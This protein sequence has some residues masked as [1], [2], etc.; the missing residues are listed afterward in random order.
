MLEDCVNIASY[1]Q[2]QSC[3]P[4]PDLHSL[5]VFAHRPCLNIKPPGL[6]KACLGQPA[7]RS[8]RA[9]LVAAAH[10][11]LERPQG[12]VAGSG[13]GRRR[14]VK[15]ENETH[16]SRA[17]EEVLSKRG[18]RFH[19]FGREF[20]SVEG[21]D[22]SHLL[23]FP[24]IKL[25]PSINCRDE[26]FWETTFI[27]IIFSPVIFPLSPSDAP[28]SQGSQAKARG[29]GKPCHKSR[30]RLQWFMEGTLKVSGHKKKQL[31]HT[32]MTFSN[33]PFLWFF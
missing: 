19:I 29:R 26:K 22:C 24:S 12:G 33:Y 14:E 1:R 15:P 27:I 32:H 11:A 9:I 6:H 3:T 5:S 17:N 30:R 31:A 2:L 16:G 23:K 4:P 7:R 18:T 13:R 8:L 25:L 20:H 10:R 28:L 21:Y